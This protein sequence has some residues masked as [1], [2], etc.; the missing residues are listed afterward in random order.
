MAPDPGKG[1]PVDDLEAEAHIERIITL[2]GPMSEEAESWYGDEGDHDQ[3]FPECP[4]LAGT[5]E[6][7]GH[8]FTVKVCQECGYMSTQDYEVAYRPW[9]CATHI[10]VSALARVLAANGSSTG[11]TDGS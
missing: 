5:G 1:V 7:E 4:A 10:A 8:T 2:H 11:G 9:P 3:R 6:C